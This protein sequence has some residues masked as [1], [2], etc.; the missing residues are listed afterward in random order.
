MVVWTLGRS[1]SQRV[2]GAL[3]R[4]AFSLYSL[5]LTC[6]VPGNGEKI[7]SLHFFLGQMTSLILEFRADT[8][9]GAISAV[10][11]VI[12]SVNT[13]TAYKYFILEK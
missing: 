10:V 1:R 4:Q 11:F 12:R 5:L 13:S 7:L 8:G 3:E 9:L 6:S 2:Q